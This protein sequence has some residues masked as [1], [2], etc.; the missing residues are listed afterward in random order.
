MKGTVIIVIKR[1]YAVGKN[2]CGQRL[3]RFLTKQGLT[4]G[5]IM[6]SIRSK[7]VK[8]GG[9]RVQADYMLNFGDNIT[10]FLPDSVNQALDSRTVSQVKFETVPTT[11]NIVYE[12]GNILLAD[13]PPGLLCHDGRDCLINRIKA[14]LYRKG[15]FS[16][17]KESSFEPSLCNRIDR[18]T[19]GIVIAAKNA[20][21]LRVMNEKIKLRQVVKLYLCILTKAPREKQATLTAFLEKDENSNT[22]KITDRKTPRNKTIITKYRILDERGALALA[23]IDLK[24]GRTHQIRAHMAYIGCP[25]LG[26]GKYGRNKINKQYGFDKQA[27]YSYKLIFN[28]IENSH[29]DYLNGRQ[30]EAADVWF[31]KEY[32]NK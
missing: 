17:E 2:D 3:D 16:P 23:E 12:D 29:L 9:K 26:D 15:E 31:L 10:L 28:F 21:T 5:V 1:E 27:L 7:D 4:I 13:K 11:V 30:F 8:V 18:N 6:K 20:E 32:Y 24:T 25:L 22:A 19:G 14:Y